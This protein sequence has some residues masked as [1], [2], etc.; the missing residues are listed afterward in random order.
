[1][2]NE[3]GRTRTIARDEARRVRVSGRSVATLHR[4]LQLRRGM[5]DFAVALALFWVVVLTCGVGSDQAYAV[6]LPALAPSA[7]LVAAPTAE[8]ASLYAAVSGDAARSFRPSGP[9]GGAHA[10][11]LLSITFAAIA[12]FNLAF[13]RHLRRVYASPRRGVWRRGSQI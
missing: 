7:S 12:A 1:M 3:D 9:A 2:R 6:P 13:L 8:P 4:T 5:I 11:A 10:V